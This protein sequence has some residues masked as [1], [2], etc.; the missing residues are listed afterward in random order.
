MRTATNCSWWCWEETWTKGK[1]QNH[2]SE[3]FNLS[4]AQWSHVNM[5][6]NIPAG[7]IIWE[8]NQLFLCF[9]HSC[10]LNFSF[11]YSC[12]NLG[13]KSCLCP[14]LCCEVLHSHELW[15]VAK[16]IA[17]GILLQPTKQIVNV[18]N[19][20][21]VKKQLSGCY[22]SRRMS[23]IWF[24]KCIPVTGDAI[25]L[26]SPGKWMCKHGS[27]DFWAFQ[28]RAKISFEKQLTKS[29]ILAPINA[30][31]SRKI[32]H[33]SHHVWTYSVF[34]KFVFLSQFGI[35]TEM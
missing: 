32:A 11:G 23:G 30:W 20:E 13:M 34:L 8:K 33:K 12:R 21:K 17:Q 29:Q 22:C 7:T 24:V 3:N 15:A 18:F 16:Q 6:K 2:K 35:Y 25:T 31:K 9:L 27:T 1:K 14:H 28:S 26:C 19:T 4:R 10:A 5:D